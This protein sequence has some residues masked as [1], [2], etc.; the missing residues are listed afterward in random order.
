MY[1]IAAV[2]RYAGE[3][4]EEASEVVTACLHRLKFKPLRDDAVNWIIS[5]SSRNR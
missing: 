5:R 1:P 4:S 3:D 2:A